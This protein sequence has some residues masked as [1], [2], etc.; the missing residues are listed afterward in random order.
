M[1]TGLTTRYDLP[2]PLPTDQVN[3]SGDI[4][5]LAVKID[6]I[7]E[8]SESTLPFLVNVA[9]GIGE[10]TLQLGYGA[11]V[12]GAT[13]TVN[14]GGNGVSGSITNINIGSSVSSALGTTTINSSSVS[15]P[16]SSISLGTITAG[17]WSGSVISSNKGGTGLSA[18]PTNGQLLIGNGTGYT[19]ATITGGSGILV[20]NS[21]GSITITAQPEDVFPNQSGNSGKFLT[22]NGTNVAWSFIAQSSVTNLTSDLALKA[23]IESPTF[24]GTP[25][26]PTASSNTSTTQIATTAFVKNNIENEVY[27]RSFLLMGS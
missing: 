15:I 19:L 18:A 26:A 9:S 14:I 7:L 13:K 6:K 24:T 21:S 25:N 10:I 4:E 12:E 2:Y 8:D 17:T 1:S 16:S 11:T 3:V 22:T 23:T 27:S 5:K 20:T